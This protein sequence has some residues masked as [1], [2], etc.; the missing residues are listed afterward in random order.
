MAKK[1]KKQTPEEEKA[2]MRGRQARAK[3]HGFENFVINE[4]LKKFWPYAMR[5]SQDNKREMIWPDVK[6]VPFFIECRSRKTADPIGL[7]EL[8]KSKAKVFKKAMEEHPEGLEKASFP[9]GPVGIFRKF[10]SRDV[11]VV[12]HIDLFIEMLEREAV[13]YK[14]QE[15]RRVG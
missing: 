13:G 2:S 9:R 10:N 7:F 8:A 14:V 6:N 11:L 5:K 1:K 12:M 4:Y 15:K 3:G